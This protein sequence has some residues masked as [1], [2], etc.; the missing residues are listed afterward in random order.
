MTRTR[1]LGAILQ[2]DHQAV[3]EVRRRAA[4]LEQRRREL[5]AERARREVLAEKVGTDRESV[6]TG[7]AERRRQLASVG[8]EVRTLVEE[9]RRRELERQT[10]EISSVPHPPT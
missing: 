7:L 6:E 4:D 8:A 10:R 2:A 3:E 9:E 1:Y 5:V